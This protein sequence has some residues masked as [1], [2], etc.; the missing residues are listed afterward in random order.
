M[1]YFY[2]CNSKSYYFVA[3]SDFMYKT[4]EALISYEEVH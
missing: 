4:S 1:F 2:L 3:I